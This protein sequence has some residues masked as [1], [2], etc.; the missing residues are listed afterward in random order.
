MSNV[1]HVDDK[2][3]TIQTLIKWMPQWNQLFIK[4]SVD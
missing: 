3:P 1:E 4:K 2:N